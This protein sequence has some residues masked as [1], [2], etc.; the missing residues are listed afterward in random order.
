MT[1]YPSIDKP[2]LKY[3]P[4]AAIDAVF[5]GKTAWELI[6]E[7]WKSHGNTTAFRYMGRKINYSTFFKAVEACAKS[8]K[9]LGVR[10][11]DIVTLILP[12]APET[13]YLFYA[14]NRI[15][16]V[17]TA[18]D[19]RLKAAEYSKRIDDLGSKFILATDIL[20]KCKY[21]I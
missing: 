20:L 12:T 7:K 17:A 14:I 21:Y 11:G 3:Y 16:A 15:G 1:G 19:P 4:K 10:Q 13:V 9:A 18:L 5:P 2:W 6:Y 8:L